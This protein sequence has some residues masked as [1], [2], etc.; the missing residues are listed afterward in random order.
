MIEGSKPGGAV[1]D[2]DLD[3]LLRERDEVKGHS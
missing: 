3:Q 1:G 2:H